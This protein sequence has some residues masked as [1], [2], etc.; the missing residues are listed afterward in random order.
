M[1]ATWLQHQDLAGTH[2]REGSFRGLG[3]GADGRELDLRGQPCPADG[4]PST[5]PDFFPSR[6]FSIETYLKAS[7]R[8]DTSTFKASFWE[9]FVPDPS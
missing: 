1:E 3:D 2:D 8:R 7:S 6:M 9:S 4:A 5:Q